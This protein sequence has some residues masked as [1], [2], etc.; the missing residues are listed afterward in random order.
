MESYELFNNKAIRDNAKLN[1]N[2]SKDQNNNSHNSFGQH[3][4]EDKF[5][6]M[7]NEEKDFKLKVLVNDL[8]IRDEKI[9]VLSYTLK[10]STAEINNLNRTISNLMNQYEIEKTEKE[11]EHKRRINKLDKYIK[12]LDNHILKLTS[13]IEKKD[14]RQKLKADKIKKTNQKDIREKENIRAELSKQMT[15]MESKDKELEKLH[16]NLEITRNKTLE[17]NDKLIKLESKTSSYSSTNNRL[18]NELKDLK[19]KYNEKTTSLQAEVERLTIKLK[20]KELKN[21]RVKKEKETGENLL[22][23]A[24]R[25]IKEKQLIEADLFTLINSENFSKVVIKSENNS[26][27]KMFNIIKTFRINDKFYNKELDKIQCEMEV[28]KKPRGAMDDKV[29]REINRKHEEQMISLHK[30]V[31][32]LVNNWEMESKKKADAIIRLEVDNE[33]L[34]ILVK[35]VDTLRM[36]IMDRDKEIST[37]KLSEKTQIEKLKEMQANSQNNEI[38]KIQDNYNKDRS[39]EGFFLNTGLFLFQKFKR[40][41]FIKEIFGKFVTATL[42][43]VDFYYKETGKPKTFK[44]KKCVHCVIFINRLINCL[45]FRL[46]AMEFQ[47]NNQNEINNDPTFRRSSMKDFFQSEQY[48]VART[49]NKFPKFNEKLHIINTM[50]CSEKSLNDPVKIMQNFYEIMFIEPRSVSLK[51]SLNLVMDVGETSNESPDENLQLSLQKKPKDF[52]S[53]KNLYMTE[54]DAGIKIQ[55]FE[56][57]SDAYDDDHRHLDEI[58]HRY[59]RASSREGSV[60]GNKSTN[61]SIDK[62]KN[63]NFFNSNENVSNF[64]QTV[65]I[66]KKAFGSTTPE[67]LLH[68]LDNLRDCSLNQIIKSAEKNRNV[69]IPNR[70]T[71]SLSNFS[72]TEKYVSPLPKIKEMVDFSDAKN[73]QNSTHR[74]DQ[75]IFTNRSEPRNYNASDEKLNSVTTKKNYDKIDFNET[76]NSQT[77]SKKEARRNEVLSYL[78]PNY[79]QR[80]YSNNEIDQKHKELDAEYVLKNTRSKLPEGPSSNEKYNISPPVRAH[81]QKPTSMKPPTQYRDEKIQSVSPNRQYK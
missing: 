31:K 48:E 12:E 63:I 52:S 26:I 44:F 34:K 50:L 11:R 14:E 30:D 7:T 39:K 73:T 70:E 3:L 66:T 72:K 49:V 1:V 33:K 74:S 56:L 53:E 35:E 71:N 54:D 55:D 79:M 16:S 40:L 22:S 27:K 46:D 37:L 36:Q 77:L 69:N 9:E 65:N 42:T 45:N 38:S 10:D 67:K 64:S 60:T 15:Q 58:K 81:S 23:E 80:K 75:K 47:A 59:S 57:T 51:F 24:R 21:E 61:K 20:K 32:E 4:E 76:T 5:R 28:Q 8:L 25:E 13:E 78:D 6:Y 68:N 62:E 17:T 2:N 41:N 18:D 29:V 43:N 19:K